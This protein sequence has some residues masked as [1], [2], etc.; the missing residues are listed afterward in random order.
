[1]KLGTELTANDDF[2]FVTS[3]RLPVAVVDSSTR[4]IIDV[5]EMEQ[6]GDLTFVV[7]GKTYSRDRRIHRVYFYPEAAY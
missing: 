1:M 5:G 4:Q 7:N 3:C 6:N 2:R